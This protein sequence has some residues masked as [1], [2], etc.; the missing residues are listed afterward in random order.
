M[1]P[2]ASG[3]SSSALKGLR[4]AMSVDVTAPLPPQYAPWP[5][6]T[7]EILLGT[8]TKAPTGF[9]AD[10][11][12]TPGS[13]PKGFEG[14]YDRLAGAA[15]QLAKRT[16]NMYALGD[17]LGVLKGLVGRGSY[18]PAI[19]ATVLRDDPTP[20]LIGHETIHRMQ[21]QNFPTRAAGTKAWN[22]RGKG[23]LAYLDAPGEQ[24][25]F[26]VE[27][28]LKARQGAKTARAR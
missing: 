4:A 26:K 13:M 24:Q 12:G 20:E 28:L 17:P 22:P 5:K 15:P 11:V 10:P 19:D 2:P 27:E 8:P 18:V 6:E 14:A 7:E 21:M 1:P 3:S 23:D 25:A 16:P 9:V